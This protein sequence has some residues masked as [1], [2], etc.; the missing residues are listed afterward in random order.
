MRRPRLST[1]V[2]AVALGLAGCASPTAGNPVPADGTST[3]APSRTTTPT[4][5]ST[6]SAPDL[7]AVRPCALLS[8]SAVRALG[9]GPGQEEK[10]GKRRSCQWVVDKPNLADNYAIAVDL[11]PDLGIKDVV[12]QGSITNTKVGSH[13]AAES[14]RRGGAGC[15]V[16]LAITET[17]RVDVAVAGGDAGALCPVARQAAALVEAELP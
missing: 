10:V 6:S 15:V 9:A 4:R 12:A 1:A 11:F 3:G 8:D 17:S 13:D 16:T 14:I 5:T 7:S 2:L